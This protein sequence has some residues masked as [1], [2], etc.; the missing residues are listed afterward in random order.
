M[1]VLLF[2]C[3][4]VSFSLVSCSVV[5]IPY[6]VRRCLPGLDDCYTQAFFEEVFVLAA[7]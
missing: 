6:G 5:A 1:L 4:V 3:F 2:F 7:S